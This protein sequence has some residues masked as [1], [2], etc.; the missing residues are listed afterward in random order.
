MSGR[1]LSAEQQRIVDWLRDGGAVFVTCGCVARI[2]KGH[3]VTTIRISTIRALERK[4]VI[5]RV[6]NGRT[7]DAIRAQHALP[8]HVD[9]YELGINAPPPAEVMS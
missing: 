7:A 9:V 4:Q 8:L 5:E 6:P 2:A 3:H 1:K